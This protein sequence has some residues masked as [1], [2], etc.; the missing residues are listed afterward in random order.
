LVSVT[1]PSTTP[2]VGG[3]EMMVSLMVVLRSNALLSWF[4]AMTPCPSSLCES[5][6]GL[7]M[8]AQ[9]AQSVLWEIRST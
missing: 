5:G 7:I 3:D 1:S 2:W 6:T 4:E 8:H 9:E